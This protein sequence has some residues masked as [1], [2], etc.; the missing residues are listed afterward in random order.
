MKLLYHPKVK[1]SDLRRMDPQVKRRIR[2]AIRSKLSD[3]P[4]SFAKPLAYT[5]QGLWSL[6]VGP[7]RVIFALRE[8][9]VWV[10]RIGHRKDVYRDL[11]GRSV[12]EDD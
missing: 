6:R 2:A 9:A 7:W 3:E 12:P 8:D 10:L 5:R 4:E 1:S 11:E